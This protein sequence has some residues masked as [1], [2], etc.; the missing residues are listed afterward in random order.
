MI[1]AVASRQRGTVLVV[2]LVVMVA[3]TLIAVFSAEGSLLDERISGNERDRAIALQAAEAALRDG[4][5]SLAVLVNGVSDCST[6]FS[7]TCVNGLCEAPVNPPAAPVWQGREALAI[8]YGRHTGATPLRFNDR[9]PPQP[10]FLVEWY[11][12]NVQV[13]DVLASDDVTRRGLFRIYAWGY[14][15]RSD[16]RV[17]LESLVAPIDNECSG[18]P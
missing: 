5:A 9:T 15:L 13:G 8:P 1:R 17:M 2:A 6:V 11:Q 14:G 16:T 12:R 3:V 10:R 18:L 7:Q 4:E